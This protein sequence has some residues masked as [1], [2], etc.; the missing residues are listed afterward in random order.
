MQAYCVIALLLISAVTSNFG[1]DVISGEFGA[2]PKVKEF[3]KPKTES[4]AKKKSTAAKSA[5]QKRYPYHGTLKTVDPAGRSIT[6]SGK[7]KD[8]V[9][10]VT[11]ETNVS[12][13]GK[14]SSLKEGRPG[15]RV[16]GSVTKNGSGQEEA[17]TVRFKGISN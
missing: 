5:P 4:P 14:K 17:L 12:R 9:I 16:S 3:S 2:A 7:K 10:L 13:D 8:R 15:E 11:E 6:L 1:N